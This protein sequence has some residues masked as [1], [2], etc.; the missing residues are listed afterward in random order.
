VIWLVS[1]MLILVLVWLV[2]RVFVSLSSR[3]L[4]SDLVRIK[5]QTDVP[6]KVLIMG[7]SAP[8]DADKAIEEA[9]FWSKDPGLYAGP[10]AQWR[11]KAGAGAHAIAGGWQQAARMI[12]AHL[13]GNKLKTIYV[14]PS[15][16]TADLLPKFKTYLETL[17]GRPLSIRPVTGKD[18][19]AYQDTTEEGAR[20]RSYDNYSYLRD[21]LIR[22]V[23][24]AKEEFEKM[25]AGGG[26]LWDNEICVDATA[27][28]KLLSIAAAVVAFDRNIVLGYVVSGGGPNPDEGIVKLYDA[29]IDFLPA[30]TN[31]IT[32]TRPQPV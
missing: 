20:R 19:Q 4:A 31:R 30:V 5:D 17:F 27:G 24:I 9:E 11:E 25:E 29:R 28:F 7:L 10:A 1:L 13:A 15:A 22:S 23:E 12:W 18:G 8:P 6:R 16:E 26:R 14:L 2:A 3:I 21:G 32:Q